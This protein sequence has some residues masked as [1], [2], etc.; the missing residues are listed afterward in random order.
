[1]IKKKRNYFLEL[2]VYLCYPIIL[3]LAFIPF[4]L[5]YALSD[6]I[7]FILFNFISYRKRTI[8]KNLSIVFPEYTERKKLK[9]GKESIRNF[10]D[11]ILEL[12][13]S[14][15]MSDARLLKHITATNLE[16]LHEIKSSNQPALFLSAHFG[17]FDLSLKAA[18]LHS[19]IKT[20]GV[21]KPFKNLAVERLLKYLRKGNKAELVAMRK[22]GWYVVESLKDKNPY[23]LGMVVD[24]SPKLPTSHYFTTFFDEPTSVFNGY[25][26]LARRLD[27]SVY[28]IH[29]HKIKRG[30][31]KSTI[32][33]ITSNARKTKRWDIVDTYYEL[34]EKQIKAQPQYYLWTHKRWKVTLENTSSIISKSP[35][36]AN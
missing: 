10:V 2:V 33:P 18:S 28:F 16:I 20:V 31:Y 14:S 21:Y 5:L 17:N 22:V 6:F 35:K 29:T 11:S 9:I 12:I 30:Y 36:L 23:I 7:T 26:S 27:L 3:V 32:V 19:G 4:K 24:Q 34:L 25:E 1:M 8:L 15:T 13:K